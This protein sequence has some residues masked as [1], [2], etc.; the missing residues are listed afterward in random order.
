LNIFPDADLF[1]LMY[2]ESKVGED[3]PKEKINTQVFSLPTQKIYNLT[4][5]Q[6]LCL[7]FMPKSVEKLN[8]SEY[9]LVIASSSG[10]AHGAKT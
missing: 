4:K 10:F 8:F 1:T 7:L 6:R 9:D 3:F 2:D 5:N